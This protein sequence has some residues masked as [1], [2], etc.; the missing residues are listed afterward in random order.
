MEYHCLDLTKCGTVFPSRSPYYWVLWLPEFSNDLPSWQISVVSLT[1]LISITLDEPGLLRLPHSCQPTIGAWC[2]R[3]WSTHDQQKIVKGFVYYDWLHILVA[4]PYRLKNFWHPHWDLVQIDNFLISFSSQRGSSIAPHKVFSNCGIRYLRTFV[5]V[6]V[7]WLQCQLRR[8]SGK[9]R[10]GLKLCT[11]AN[12]S[13]PV[14]FGGSN[15]LFEP[16]YGI[17][18]I[19]K[20]FSVR[21]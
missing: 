4:S 9:R 15:R 17:E 14:T 3:Y 6:S 13:T 20:I 21:R 19:N 11:K 18:D 7:N 12:W 8:N 2:Y 10:T 5:P 16:A 1:A